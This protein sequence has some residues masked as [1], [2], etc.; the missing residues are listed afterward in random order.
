LIRDKQYVQALA[1][2]ES[3]AKY[4]LPKSARA[5]HAALKTELSARMTP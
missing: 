4:P 3:A 2:L 1:T 5:Y